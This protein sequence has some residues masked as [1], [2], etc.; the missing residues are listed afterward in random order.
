LNNSN[1]MNVSIIKNIMLRCVLGILAFMLVD[2]CK[3]DERLLFHEETSV[4]FTDVDSLNY[5]FA[6]EGPT[7]MT[8]TV[9]IGT[10]IS[11]ASVNHQRPINVLLETESTA[12][13]GYHFE[14]LDAF[15]SADSYS[16][17]IALVLHRRPGLQDSI[18]TGRLRIVDG[19]ELSA[20]YAT[21]TDF[22]FSFSDQLVKPTNWDSFW[23][24]VF[25]AYSRVKLQFLASTTGKTDWDVNVSWPAERSFLIQTAK[26]GLFEYVEANGP[27]IDENGNPVVFP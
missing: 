1:I 7:V 22:R 14:L 10:R 16:G 24:G 20:G 13:L 18:V 15:I 11:G 8:D 12:K 2:G 6:L 9:Y 25:G 3:E 21:D 27:L 19:E 5:S 4:Y 23:S 26:F 17:T